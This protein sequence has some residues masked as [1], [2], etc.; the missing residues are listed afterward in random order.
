MSKL[1]L[2]KM[3]LDR[4][5]RLAAINKTIVEENDKVIA[6]NNKLIEYLKNELKTL[7]N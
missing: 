7:E 3:I 4:N 5:A 6:E 1:E 2:I